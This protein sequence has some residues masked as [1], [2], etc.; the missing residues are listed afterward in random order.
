VAGCLNKF[1]GSRHAV[2]T[3]SPW[4]SHFFSLK[5]E[6][7]LHST[8]RSH[9]PRSLSRLTALLSDYHSNVTDGTLDT[10]VKDRQQDRRLEPA[11]IGANKT[12][13]EKNNG[14]ILEFTKLSTEK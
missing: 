9:S 2:V 7:V 12:D 11:Y 1:I 13:N 8:M 14:P 6:A 4:V 5:W 3:A 10:V